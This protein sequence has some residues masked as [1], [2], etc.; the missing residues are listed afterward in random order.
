SHEAVYRVFDPR[1]N[2]EALLRHLGEA[3]MQDAVRPDEFRQRFAATV[4]VRH[5]HVMATFEILEI[6]GRPAVLQEWLTGLPS[7]DW[8]ALAR[9]AL[10]WAAPATDSKKGSRPKRLPASLQVVL[11]RLCGE[12]GTEPYSSAA[13]LLEALDAAGAAVPANAAAWER[14]VRQVREQSSD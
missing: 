9:R 13:A 8:P 5:P 7:G 11:Q 2:R 1:G 14:F 6:A 12:E 3:E 10:G 4:E